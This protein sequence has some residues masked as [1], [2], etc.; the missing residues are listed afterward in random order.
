MTARSPMIG[1][2]RPS[3]ANSGAEFPDHDDPFGRRRHSAGERPACRRTCSSTVHAQPSP[4]CARSPAR[5]PP[6]GRPRLGFSAEIPL[7]ARGADA[8][9]FVVAIAGHVVDAL[10]VVVADVAL[11]VAATSITC[12]DARSVPGGGRQAIAPAPV[13]WRNK[14]PSPHSALCRFRSRLLAHVRPRVSTV[15]H[16]PNPRGPA[17]H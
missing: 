7:T 5:S 9:A 17:R 1:W 13:P 14:F 8:R 4:R 11:D 16:R 6:A 10:R 12:S 15:G 2:S 3:S